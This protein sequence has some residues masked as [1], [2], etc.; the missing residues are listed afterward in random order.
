[1]FAADGPYQV[2]QTW[3]LGGDGGW[4]YLTVDAPAHLLYI[5]RGNRVM[6]VD[7]NSGQLVRE[8]TGF[9]GIHG[10]ALDSDGRYGYVSDG[11]AGEA[12][13]FDRASGQVVTSIPVG[14]NPDA[15]VFEPTKKYVITL[16]GGSSDASVIDT[17]SKKVIATIS[18]PGRPEFAAA[19]GKGS[20]Y[21]NIEDKSELARIDAGTLK[22]TGV[23][24]LAPCEG[25]SGLAMDT[26]KRRLFSVC[27]GKTMAVTDADSGKVVAT[28]A[29][30]NGP[31]AAAFDA[32]QGVAFSS[33]GQDGTLTVVHQDS[34]DK[35]SVL[36]TVTTKKSARTMALDTSTGKIYLVG[37]DFGPRPEAPTPDNPRRWPPVLPG[38]FSVIVVGR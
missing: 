14:K 30:G 16:N 24:P 34:A 10:V 2:V 38:T 29:I 12:K 7:V 37:A 6:V 36:E 28:A 20:V 31:D 23:W 32:K 5:T 9:Q 18:L 26:G 15:I 13:V 3:K 33:N 4:D 11:R 8:I 27:D 21:V 1:L 19:D 22:V 35:Y 17:A 25:P